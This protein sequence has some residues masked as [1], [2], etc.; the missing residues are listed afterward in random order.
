MPRYVILEHDHP[1]LHW[2][3][4]LEAGESL[5]TWRL[6]APPQPAQTVRA[7]EISAHRRFYLDYEGPISG[8]RGSVRRWDA[9]TFTGEVAG[10]AVIVAL[11]GRR[12]QCQARLESDAAGARWHFGELPREP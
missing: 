11:E 12:L 5:R 4:L 3:F 7:E 2:D 1:F 6:A 8:G 10:P 9:G